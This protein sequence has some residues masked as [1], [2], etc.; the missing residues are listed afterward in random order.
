M[1]F[2]ASWLLFAVVTLTLREGSGFLSISRNAGRYNCIDGKSLS[3]TS[4]PFADSMQTIYPLSIQ[5]QRKSIANV[6]TMGLFGLGT[7]EII[8]ILGAAAFLIGPQQLGKWAGELK[9]DLPDDIKRIP[10]EF[11]KGVEEGEVASRARRAK[12]MDALPDE[13]KE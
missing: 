10:E 8:V 5:R 13:D 3:K 9:T 12:P 11:Q 1:K 7:L 6:Q 4:G 2:V